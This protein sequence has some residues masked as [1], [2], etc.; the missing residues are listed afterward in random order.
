MDGDG[1]EV[2]VGPAAGNLSARDL[3]LGTLSQQRS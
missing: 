2:F 3:S 1:L